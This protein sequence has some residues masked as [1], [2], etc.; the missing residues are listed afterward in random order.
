MYYKLQI[1]KNCQDDML[2]LWSSKMASSAGKQNGQNGAG[3]K[4]PSGYGLEFGED[5]Y[6]MTVVYE[7]LHTSFFDN[8]GIAILM[9]HDCSQTLLT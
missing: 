4:F 1:L 9:L 6:M 8:S 2:F 3:E 7:Y 5:Y